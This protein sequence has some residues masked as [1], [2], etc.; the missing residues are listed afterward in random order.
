MAPIYRIKFTRNAA[1]HLQEIFDYIEKDSAQNA[2]R[3]IGRIVDAIDALEQLP[4]RYRVL[5]G[6]D[7]HGVE[8][9]S[10]PV[11]PYL[12]R[13]HVDDVNFVVTVLSVRH[14]ARRPGL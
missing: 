10:M 6:V 2:S 4:H 13:Y 11:P 3:M 1:D 7:T 8:V 5:P 14:G 12:V 9:R